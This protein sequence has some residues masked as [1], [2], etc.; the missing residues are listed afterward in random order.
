MRAQHRE[1]IDGDDEWRCR[2]RC[3]RSLVLLVG[4]LT[5]TTQLLLACFVLDR[6]SASSTAWL[7]ID[8]AKLTAMINGTAGTV[9]CMSMSL[10]FPCCVC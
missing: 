1:L 5:L 9:S 2:G 7:Q 4:S 8:V 3:S 10:S 6:E